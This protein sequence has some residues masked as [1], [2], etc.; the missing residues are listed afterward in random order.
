MRVLR[1]HWQLLVVTGMIVSSVL[2]FVVY[3]VY[4]VSPQVSSPDLAMISELT[5][6]EFPS[7]SELVGSQLRREMAARSLQVKLRFPRLHLKEFLRVLPVG[8][9]KSARTVSGVVPESHNKLWWNPAEVCTFV[10]G[11]WELETG[12][13]VYVTIST[14]DPQY[15]TVFVVWVQ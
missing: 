2:A 4:M 13:A 9:R 15:A 1:H 7:D 12:E 5:H 6:I 14:D 8:L 10:G 11:S 3:S